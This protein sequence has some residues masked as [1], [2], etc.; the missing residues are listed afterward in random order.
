ML[1]SEEALQITKKI[2]D[3][4][5]VYEMAGKTPTPFVLTEEE[6]RVLI[7]FMEQSFYSNK[8]MKTYMGV[9]IVIKRERYHPA[10]E[11][12]RLYQELG[13]MLIHVK[14][15]IKRFSTT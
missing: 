10:N 7:N 6:H 5:E 8:E 15:L 9:E 11:L 1:R 12:E 3:H 14:D 2:H 4:V 13:Q